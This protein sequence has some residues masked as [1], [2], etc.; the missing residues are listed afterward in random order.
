[1]QIAFNTKKNFDHPK[2]LKTS[3]DNTAFVN[4]NKP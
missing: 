1:M 3:D 4:I 2:G